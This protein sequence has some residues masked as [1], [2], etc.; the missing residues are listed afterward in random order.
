M[1]NPQN[2]TPKNTD[3][4]V[5]GASVAYPALAHWPHLHGLQDPRDHHTLTTGDGLFPSLRA[6]RPHD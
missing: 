1:T 5:T 2:T 3:I 4:L 6:A